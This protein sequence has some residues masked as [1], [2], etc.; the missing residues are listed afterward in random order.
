MADV[1]SFFRALYIPVAVIPDLDLVK[2]DGVIRK[3]LAA[4]AT[5]S[6]VADAI[7]EECRRAAAAIRN[8]PP[9][10]SPDD[11]KAEINRISGLSMDW[12]R[13]D[14][15]AVMRQLR[16]LAN[17]VERMRKLKKGG[18]NRSPLFR[19]HMYLSD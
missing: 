19:V 16:E 12:Q 4:L 1:A 15:E 17:K 8:V 14:D 7:Q 2:D 13:S 18:S 3:L 10:I 11:V 9:T 6:G 5:D